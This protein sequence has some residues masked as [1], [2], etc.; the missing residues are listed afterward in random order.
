MIILGFHC[1]MRN[2]E[3]MKLRIMDISIF[4]GGQGQL[5]LLHTKIGQRLGITELVEKKILE[6]FLRL[7]GRFAR[8][9]AVAEF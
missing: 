8:R 1:L 7:I 6:A 9:R 3:F 2:C 4:P 5:R